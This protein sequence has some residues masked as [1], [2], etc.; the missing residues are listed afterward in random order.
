MKNYIVKDPKELADLGI[1]FWPRLKRGSKLA[2][3][4]IEFELLSQHPQTGFMPLGAYSY[5]HSLFNAKSVGR[6]CSIASNVKVMGNSHPHHWVTT[7]PITYKPRRRKKLGIEEKGLGLNYAERP[8]PVS[9]GH[10]VWIGSD[11]IMKA[12]VRVCDGAVIAAG[13]VVVKDVDAFTIVGGNPAVP[14]RRRFDDSLVSDLKALQWWRYKFDDLQLLDFSD[15]NQFV[16][17]FPD[18]ADLV[19][20]P[21]RRLTVSEHIH[22]CS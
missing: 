3:S 19:E 20:L 13:S 5:S 2:N 11:V 7:S 1:Q 12:G 10:D 17:S 6:Y 18:K 16:K 4:G 21:E 14:I 15:P 8:E 9:I 22:E